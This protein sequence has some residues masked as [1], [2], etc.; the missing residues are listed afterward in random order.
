MDCRIKTKMI[1]QAFGAL[2]FSHL[3]AGVE[4]RR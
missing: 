3:V 4:A 1:W 2:R